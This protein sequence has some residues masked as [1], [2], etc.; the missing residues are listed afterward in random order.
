MTRSAAL[1]LLLFASPVFAEDSSIF[2]SALRQPEST[3]AESPRTAFGAA[4]STWWG[5]GAG[6]AHNFSGSTDSNFNV[7][8]SYF[9]ANDVEFSAELGAWNFNQPGENAWGVNPSMVFRWHFYNDA[10]WSIYTDVG[11]GV[12]FASDMVPDGGTSFDFMPRAGI[13][14]TR[15]LSDDGTRLQA[16]IRWHHISNARIL[17]DSNNPARDAPMI[18]VGLQFPF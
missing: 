12:L 17:G 5:L 2:R 14:F 4:E 8:Y 9:L 15:E 18:Y 11:I 16:G 7:S 10:K 3:P 1:A 6:V 13:G